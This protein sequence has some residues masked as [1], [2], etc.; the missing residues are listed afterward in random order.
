MKTIWKYLIL[1]TA[2]AT[3]SISCDTHRSEPEEDDTLKDIYRSVN[4]FAYNILN[5][6][7]LWIE[8]IK[9]KMS[10]WMLTDEPI[11]KV[12]ELRYK[13]SSGNDIDR[14]TSLTDK[15]SDYMATVSGTGRTYGYE[16]RLYRLSADTEDIAAVII[17]TY[18]NSPAA[19]AG[20]K[21]GDVITKVNGKKMTMD[22][23]VSI[24][25]NELLGGDSAKLTLMNGTEV[26][27]TSVK[28]YED[29]V[30]TTAIL[31]AGGH[32][33]GYL[34]FTS[35]T[36]DACSSLV[37]V[38]REFREAGIEHLVL[39]L[40]YNGG[41]YVKTEDLLASM[42]AP[43]E[44]VKRGDVFT[45]QVYNKTLRDVFGE[46]ATKFTSS[47]AFT[48][49]DRKYEFDTSDANT[50][51][52]HLWVIT[53]GSTAS[54]SE[55]L[56]CGLKP[57]ID[58]TLVGEKTSGKY[59]GGIIIQ[60]KE[61]YDSVKDK[62]DAEMYNQGIKLASTWGIYVM[63]SRYADKDGKTLSMPDGITPDYELSDVPMDG[64]Q[65]GDP[66]ETMLAF[67]LGLISGQSPTVPTKSAIQAIP[68][69]MPE[70]SGS[71]ILPEDLPSFNNELTLR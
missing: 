14:W 5:T 65:L 39:D 51:I 61:W 38:C 16:V 60:A 69:D 25:N 68:V 54:A 36:L 29:P 3:F 67:V 55:S 46:E 64:H 7:Y 37:K 15:V 56:I 45:T 48:V 47:F 33:T 2:A 71:I 8:E 6:Y 19:K 52:S 23:Y 28:M 59:C 57:Y 1:L 24:V 18:N 62:M 32:K 43:E 53:T 9:P 17:Y 21:R 12:K 58:V 27:L 26:S 40:R 34:H 50:G 30:G 49:D 22:N 70:W 31:D 41:G 66:K 10:S 4:T 42:L 11:A 63:I 20:L 13:D 35:F 44:S